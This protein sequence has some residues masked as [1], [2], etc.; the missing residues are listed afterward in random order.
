M[1]ADRQSL[2]REKDS[3]GSPPRLCL[4]ALTWFF[5]LESFIGDFEISF[6]N[7]L[8]TQHEPPALL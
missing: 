7:W 8:Q 1:V 3:T 4:P 2:R 6:F 5:F